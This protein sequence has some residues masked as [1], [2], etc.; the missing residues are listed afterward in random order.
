MSGNPPYDN[1]YA[2]LPTTDAPSSSSSST[3][4]MTYP[5]SFAPQL[6]SS[7]SSGQGQGQ[8]YHGPIGSI[9]ANSMMTL[10]NDDT[11]E[12]HPKRWSGIPPH[13]ADDDSKRNN[14]NN[15]D[16]DAYDPYHERADF[17]L[18]SP[19]PNPNPSD[20]YA[21]TSPPEHVIGRNDSKRLSYI[22]IARPEG[23]KMFSP[24]WFK[25]HW[26]VQ[27]SVKRL[28][29][30]FYIASGVFLL[31]LWIVTTLVFG[32]RLESNE[33]SN[34]I[35]SVNGSGA[36]PHPPDRI[37]TLFLV[38]QLN[39]F[40]PVTRNLNIDW[41][42][43]RVEK[44]SN[45]MD[46]LSGKLDLLSMQIDIDRRND[47]VPLAMF[48]DVLAV[49]DTDMNITDYQPFRLQNPFV[50]PVGFLGLNQYEQ[51]NTDIGLG[52]RAQ[53][54]WRQPDFGY[55]FDMYQ[56]KITWVAAN[57][58]TIT[59]TGRPGTD[60]QPI[61][62]AILTDS[63]LNMKVRAEVFASCLYL[64]Q[65]GCELIIQIWVTRTGLVKFCVFVVFAIH[66]FV[67]IA[68]FLLTGESLLLSRHNIL[69]STDIFAVCF[70]ALV[71]EQFDGG[72]DD[73]TDIL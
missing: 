14:N 58:K 41:T 17:E 37:G 46:L 15:N 68:R 22:S 1:P 62:G 53:N 40:D 10:K 54:V 66:W 42:A 28:G 23:M 45:Q 27:S 43:I 67:T 63:L 35:I 60:V 20:P 29:R 56:G 13:V 33:L 11:D 2:S 30:L 65:P 4:P 18:L 8:G 48:R 36:L 16:N 21:D 51:V 47:T 72:T 24:A 32:N 59:A 19:N 69:E 39:S 5:P 9:S 6:Q 73:K 34:M 49:P 55:P 26:A 31:F 70:S 7:N 12:S 71:S 44:P 52:Q 57:N 3:I 50:K 25:Y 38:G 64:D 61:S